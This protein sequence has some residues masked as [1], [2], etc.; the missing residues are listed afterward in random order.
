MRVGL[1]ILYSFY[2]SL[3]VFFEI[4]C[5]NQNQIQD[6][7]VELIPA[8]TFIF[9][10]FVDC[11]MATAWVG[12]TFRIFPGKYGEDPVWG[13]AHDLKFA[14][15]A[16]A[17]ET[18]NTPFGSFSEPLMPAVAATKE[19]G[20]HGA[21]W[22][23]TVY[24]DKNDAS[25][26]TLFALY[27]NENYPQTLPY[28]AAT[29]QGYKN[30]NWPFGINTDTSPAAVP[31]IGIMKSL[32]GGH[33]WENKGIILEDL[34]DRM[35][36][37]PDNNAKSFGGGNG[38]PSAIACG[39][40]L[41]IFYSEYGYPGKYDP[42]TYNPEKEHQGQCISVA[43][44]ALADLNNPQGKAKRWNGK[45]FE[46]SYTDFGQPIKEFV[47]PSAEGGGPTSTFQAD[48]YWGPS[49]SWNAYLNAWVMLMAKTE[50]SSW[51]GH[52]IYISFNT[53]KDL[54]LNDNSQQWSKPQLLYRK[55]GHTLWY[56]SLQPLN[57]KEDINLKRTCLNLGQEAR[58][59]FKDLQ[60]DKYL[61]EFKVRFSKKN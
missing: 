48:F 33:S 60:R 49:V 12:D 25:G 45:A 38:D 19:N 23:E 46:S 30:I 14:N 11:N 36:L 34:Q 54:G 29:G 40:Y 35:I 32:D 52:S 22:F 50:D 8:D 56:P 13:P 53:N 51:V 44:L 42:K 9:R 18:F 27:H 26:K 1:K 5:H 55:E 41:Y 28:N 57:T 24:Q 43:R 2:C 61:S 7:K 59:F 47:I 39:D 21:V 31:R 4:N 37:S 10:S 15:G 6:F 3:F 20:L 58:L 17:D 16:N